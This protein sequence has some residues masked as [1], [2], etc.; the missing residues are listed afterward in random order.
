MARWPVRIQA[1][2]LGEVT[3]AQPLRTDVRAD[4]QPTLYTL[5]ALSGVGVEHLALKFPDT[6]YAG[7]LNEPGYN[8][9]F[10]EDGV[11]DSWVRGLSFHN[12][13]SGLL[14][15]D[16]TKHITG[17][18][19]SFTGRQG[20]H[21]LNIAHTHD[22]LYT[23]LV[24]D[25]YFVHH[26]TVDHRASGNVFSR[27]SGEGQPIHLDHHRDS[28]FENLWTAIRGEADLINGGSWCAGPPSGARSTFWGLE[29]PLIPPYWAHVQTNMVGPST[30]DQDE[31]SEHGAWIER[32]DEVQPRNLHLAQR[33][34]R[35]GLSYEDTGLGEDPPDPA[36]DPTCG[37]KGGPA[38]G[39]GSVLLG[40]LALRRRRHGVS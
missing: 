27:V 39:L 33:A 31:L 36:A 28:P 3:L 11:V 25:A 17:Q 29:A 1:V 40:L 19:L 7:H 10:F 20:H 2:G 22:G 18:Q 13:D 9:V 21:G 23:D 12:A 6:E 38:A 14:V 30:A 8:G 24:F 26:M 37:C 34:Q 35:L 32:M 4:W 15:D 16:L 5:G